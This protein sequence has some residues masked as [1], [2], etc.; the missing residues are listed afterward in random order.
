[1]TPRR[2]RGGATH[3]AAVMQTRKSRNRGILPVALLR[4]S[5]SGSMLLRRSPPA[6]NEL[7]SASIDDPPLPRAGS[8][9]PW[10]LVGLVPCVVV[11]LLGLLQVPSE[12]GISYLALASRFARG[13]W[14]EALAS[15]FP[16][17][18]PLLC[19]PLVAAGLDVEVAAVSVGAACL[20]AALWPL[21][22]A[23]ERLRAGAGGIAPWLVF[24][25]PLLPRLAAEVYSEPPFVLAT[26]LAAACG[27]RQRWWSLGVWSGVAF[28]IRP[29]GLLLA[30]AFGIARP[31]V[32]WRALLP[33]AGFV[34]GLAA[35]RAA[36]GH[37]FEPLPLLAFHDA[38]DDLPDRGAWLTNLAR[39]PIV[40]VE[41]LGAVAL[42][43]LVGIVRGRA[44]GS[45][46]HRA[47]GW[48]VAL[49]VLA[50]CSFVARKRFFVSAFVPVALLAAAELANWPRRA[51]W[52]ALLLCLGI[53]L[54]AVVPGGDG[55]DRAVEPELGRH[56]G[57][58]LRPGG[59]VFAD[60]PRVVYYAGCEP[61]PPRHFDAGQ[62]AALATRDAVQFVVVSTASKRDSS[63]EVLP[64]LAAAFAPFPLPEP[65]AGRCAARGLVVFARR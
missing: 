64:A 44:T 20:V 42:V 21:A 23:A 48:S 50:V 27:L 53:G 62:F 57:H 65:L 51:R 10:L 45:G 39:V 43:S 1:M 47:L 41:G 26:A 35:L 22:Q 52:V 60:L 46:G 28:W 12:D 15:V 5:F 61:P 18:F 59:T 24:A 13:E 56:L 34:F 54:A 33:A 4:N 29:E 3:L 32:A 63:R 58:L 37:A 38:R 36:A 6:V 30:V 2:R 55:V 14:H 17:G 49:Q 16:P 40:F 7:P 25:S 9:P 19:A 11:G 31:R 8:R